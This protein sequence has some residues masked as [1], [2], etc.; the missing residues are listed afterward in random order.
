M[1]KNIIT[2]GLAVAGLSG[3]ADVYTV[4]NA[5]PNF[6]VSV[7]SGSNTAYLTWSKGLGANS[8]IYNSATNQFASPASTF[9]N[10]EAAGFV[11][12]ATAPAA[13]TNQFCIYFP[14]NTD[15]GKAM[16]STA[17]TAKAMGSYLSLN[18]NKAAFAAGQGY[19]IWF[20]AATGAI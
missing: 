7:N 5:S 6:S 18:W 3:A 4:Y 14:I 17:L 1:F 19:P 16:L 13:N 10:V 9:C 11:L 15:A 8:I 20:L 12:S 2:I